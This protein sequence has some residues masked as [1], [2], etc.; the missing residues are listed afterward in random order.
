MIKMYQQILNYEPHNEKSKF[1]LILFQKV[2]MKLMG[3]LDFYI[4]K[5][6][7]LLY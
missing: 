4:D 6:Y 5:P 3:G 2:I 1:Y 7:N